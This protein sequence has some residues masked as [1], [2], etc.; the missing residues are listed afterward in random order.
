MREKEY[1]MTFNQFITQFASEVQCRQYLYNLR[2]P[3]GF[4]CPK[5]SHNKSWLRSNDL[6][7]CANCKHG[8]SVTA[9]TIFQDTRKPLKDWFVAIWWITTQKYGA[10]AQGLQQILGLKSYQTAWTWLHKIRTAMV[11]PSR[12]KLSGTVEVDEAYIGGEYAGK[13]GRGSENKSPI[14]VAV[15]LDGKKL[16]RIRISI[17]NDASGD[18]LIPFVEENIEKDSKL[19]TDS[20]SGFSG[21]E[22]KGYERIIHNQ[23]TATTEDEK[24][25]H[26]HLIISL[27]KRWLLG[28]HQGAVDEK[29]LQAYLDEYVFRFNRRKSAQRGLLF[30]RLLENA[31]I[32]PPTTYRNFVNKP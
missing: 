22:S 7:E 27:L 13:A 5:C 14:A 17:I 8:T 30:Y 32:I 29:H 19:I 9:G 20:W 21:I 1:P 2:F 4:I 16:G 15:E 24:L 23:T 10:S 6:Y 11:C 3:D 31:M 18:S 25:P 28:T 26:V 12:S